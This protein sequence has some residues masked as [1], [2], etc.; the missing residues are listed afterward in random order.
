MFKRN[1]IIECAKKYLGKKYNFINYDVDSEKS[2]IEAIGEGGSGI[3]YLAEQKL[4]NIDT[5]KV[6]R[7]IKFFVY[8]DDLREQWGAVSADNFEV[9]IVNIT[10]FNH[11]NVLKVIDGD[12]FEG[13]IDGEV[14]HIPYTVTEYVEGYNLQEFLNEGNKFLSIFKTQ[15]DVFMLIIQIL[16]GIKYLHKMNFYHC[17]IA[18]KNIFIK[19]VEASNSFV[20]VIGDLGAGKTKNEKQLNKETRI[21]GTKEYMPDKIKEI[22]NKSVSYKKFFEL[23]PEWDVFSTI[24]T[25]SEI[26]SAAKKYNVC[27][28]LWSLERLEESLIKKRYET[29][30]EI[31]DL[32][33]NL[34]PN[35]RVIIN[36][37]ELSEASNKIKASLLAVTPVY[38]S[39]RI[40][41]IY[42]HPMVLRLMDVSQLLEGATTFPSANHTRYEHSL[43]T[44][45]LMRK[46][47]LALLRNKEYVG[48]L[49]DKLVATGLLAALLSSLSCFPHSYVI[50]ELQIS[51][52]KIF[53][54][55]TAPKVFDKLYSL[56]VEQ[57]SIESLIKNMFPMEIRK[58]DIKY[59]IFGKSGHRRKELE[60]LNK[61]LN[62]SVGVRIIDYLMRDAHH[63]GLA[64]KIDTEDL[65][66]N[67]VIVNSGM[68]LSPQGVS[69]AEQI[70]SNRYWMFK[71]IYWN[72]PNR[73]NCAILKFIY[74]MMQEYDSE[75]ESELWKA[76]PKLD[77]KSIW[78]FLENRNEEISDKKVKGRI[79]SLISIM[80]QKG[81]KRYKRILVLNKGSTFESAGEI[82]MKIKNKTFSE[83]CD[84][85][86][87]LEKYIIYKYDI[88][89]KLQKLQGVIIDIPKEKLQN[90][91]GKDIYVRR[92]DTSTLEIEKLSGIIKGLSD[93][94][95]EQLMWLRIYCHPD[96][97]KYLFEEKK[98]SIK[99]VEEDLVKYFIEEL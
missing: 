39:Y 93:A 99:E 14:V 45:E 57:K 64:Y 16:N 69:V 88:P 34:D 66:E 23:Q 1:E 46:A 48:I 62:S 38:S 5:A 36:L 53:P 13:E 80:K 29:I 89:K 42:K 8:R 73:A 4:G 56:K 27:G 82:Y 35:K 76:I 2:I 94:F 85:Q 59:V 17:D 32:V 3:V 74:F 25:I 24:K 52:P 20:A 54:K 78:T 98:I 47:F 49:S 75:F 18:P 60:L 6:K 30:Q 65:F 26:I 79:N 51:E 28:G 11:E 50:S 19:I 77:E 96:Y 43:G 81:S 95:E 9:E 10:Q 58:E 41:A 61:L 86:I 44:Y 83:I 70:I 71:R 55:L 90:K 12:L 97:Y 72:D 7:A 31:L 33:N 84:I 87:N 91:T 40:R 21:I 15:E 68:H 63:I 37:D 22:K 92:Y 67:M